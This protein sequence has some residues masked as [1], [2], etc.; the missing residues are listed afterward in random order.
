MVRRLPGRF[1]PRS[2]DLLLFR[3]LS[4]SFFLI[5]GSVDLLKAFLLNE[6]FRVSLFS[7]LTDFLFLLAGRRFPA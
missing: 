7:L 5:A 6:H 3:M 2:F 1:L 4:V